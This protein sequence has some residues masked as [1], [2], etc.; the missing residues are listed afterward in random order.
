VIDANVAVWAVVPV[1]AEIRTLDL[2]QHWHQQRHQILAPDLWIAEA[3]SVIRRLVY[4][5]L[6]SMAEAQQ[7]IDDLFDLEIQTIPLTR[8]LCQAALTWASK[9][10]H[11]RV[12]DSTYLA[13]TEQEQAHLWTADKRLVNGAKQRGFSHISWI[14]DAKVEEI[15][16]EQENIE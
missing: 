12:Y 14:G 5:K 2:L 6:L 8:P 16:V 3:V 4:M 15:P 9:L 13:V 7:A 1:I 11:A 10:Q